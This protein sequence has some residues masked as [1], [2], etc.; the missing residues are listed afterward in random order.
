M[1][2]GRQHFGD[3]TDCASVKRNR[4]VECLTM[5]IKGAMRYT[6]M[7]MP[8]IKLMA[9]MLVCEAAHEITVDPPS[10]IH[11]TDPGHLG[12]LYITWKPPASLKNRT[13]CAV[14][15]QLQYFDTYEEE[16]TTIRTRQRSYSAQFDLGKNV[17]V[18]LQTL[19]GGPCRSGSKEIQ[20]LPAEVLLEPQAVGLPGTKINDFNCV[21]YQREYMNC[22]WHQGHETP[23]KARH[24]LY[25][26]HR[27]MDR[28]MECPRYLQIHGHRSGCRFSRHYL[29]EF[30]EFNVCV[31]GS[32]ADAPLQP[33]YFSLRLQNYVKPGVI[34]GLSLET[35][36]DGEVSLKWTPPKGRI[37]EGCLQYEVEYRSMDSDEL[38]AVNLTRENFLTISCSDQCERFCFRVRSRVLEFCADGGFWSD[39]SHKH[40]QSA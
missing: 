18:R 39:W 32:S 14:R 33:A 37:P 25:F 4:P 26:W 21:Y 1:L 15:Y 5:P 36:P 31:N 22:T 16:W 28:A 29:L 20:S 23:P 13:D 7:W 10:S 30:T 17:H 12:E 6:P 9:L 27:E 35:V 3:F 11:I 34:D 24:H 19:L 38:R 40:C 2:S 8:L